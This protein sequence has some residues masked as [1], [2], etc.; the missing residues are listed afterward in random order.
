MKVQTS[1]IHPPEL[2]LTLPPHQRTRITHVSL[3]A[4]S[5]IQSRQGR[6]P[7]WEI[8]QQ[9]HNIR[10]VLKVYPYHIL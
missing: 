5:L 1:D 9:Q 8:R 3:A 10:V 4:Q 2:L 7:R 6:K